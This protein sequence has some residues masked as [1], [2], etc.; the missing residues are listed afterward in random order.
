MFPV[1]ARRLALML[2]ALVAAAPVLSA[3]AAPSRGYRYVLR[4]DAEHG[5]HLVAT[6]RDAG[7]RARL[8]FDSHDPNDD[9]YLL[10][11]QGGRRIV[12]VH[13][14]EREFSIVND[15]TLER[16]IG[17][18]LHAVTDIGL[19]QFRVSDVEIT[20]ES[21]GTGDQVLGRPTQRYRLT[22]DFT[23]IIRALGIAGDEIHQTVVTEYWVD[24]TV[25]LMRN[26]VLE[27]LAAVETALAQSS[28][29][30]TRRSAEARHALFGGF[31]L[32]IV[33]T[34]TSSGGDEAGRTK[35][36]RLEVTSLERASFDPAQFEVPPG[37]RRRAGDFSLRF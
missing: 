24:P 33:V 19:V 37:F 29:G 26:P 25:P 9:S 21:L 20:P 17:K 32:K 14:R 18:A 4:M 10:L 2:V 30:F 5:D 1:A 6:V 8:D 23:V 22:Q 15:T 13:P 11:L 12:S 27:M 35:T 28:R 7:D 3:Q 34:S 36:R 16:I 31:P